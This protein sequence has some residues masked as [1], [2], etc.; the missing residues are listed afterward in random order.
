[1][2]LIRTALLLVPFSAAVMLVSGCE[3]KG[4]ERADPEKDTEGKAS[5]P[6]AVVVRSGSSNSGN[7]RDQAGNG[8]AG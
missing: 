2:Q 3:Q 6:I 4:R 1:M 7:V 8:A 5:E